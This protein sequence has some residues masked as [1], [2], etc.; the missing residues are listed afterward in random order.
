MDNFNF[1]FD[2]VKDNNILRICLQDVAY[3]GDAYSRAMSDAIVE[4]LKKRG[5]LDANGKKK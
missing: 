1:N 4:E 5:E 3:K 2:H